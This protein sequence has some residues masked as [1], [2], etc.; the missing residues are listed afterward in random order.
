MTDDFDAFFEQRQKAASAYVGGDGG[1]VDA[2]VPHEGD[3][4]FLSPGGDSVAGAK[5]VAARY[6]KDAKG[7]KPGG[8]SQFEVLQ[9]ASD[10]KLA[11]WTGYQVAR[12]QIGEM[13]K[14]MDMR[15]RVTEVFRKIDGD[16]KM[17]HRHA[18]MGETAGK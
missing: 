11:F 10:G 8:K 14:P 15:V 12:V 18:D 16:W 9:K 17:I 6:L 3:A 5:S 4:S 2:L 1:L 13:P 7:F